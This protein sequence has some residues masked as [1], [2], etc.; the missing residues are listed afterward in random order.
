MKLSG[1]RLKD[2]MKHYEDLNNQFN[3]EQFLEQIQ[4]CYK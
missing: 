4:K 2:I 1:S 3:L